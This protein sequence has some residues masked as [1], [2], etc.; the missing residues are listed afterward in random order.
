MKVTLSIEK[1]IV[2]KDEV[3]FNLEAG[4]TIDNSADGFIPLLKH[5]NNN[6]FMVGAT[7]SHS[8]WDDHYSYN[9]GGYNS[10]DLSRVEV[11]HSNRNSIALKIQWARGSDFA[12]VILNKNVT[13]EDF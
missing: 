10:V 8:K 9:Q 1:K 2:V 11:I 5:L 7:T 3:T 13:D 6:F 4:F 12:V